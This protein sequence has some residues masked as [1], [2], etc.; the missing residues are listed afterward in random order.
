MLDKPPSEPKWQSWAYVAGFSCVIFLTVPFARALQSL[1]SDSVGR[2][3]FLI[4]VV[5]AGTFAAFFAWRSIRH[6]EL[7]VSAYIALVAVGTAFAIY[8]YALRENPEEALHFVEY[9]ILGVL[10]YRA[11]T[12]SVH[13]V[14]IY[15]SAALIVT[16]VGVIDEWIQ[17]LTPRR[18]WDLRDI[19]INCVAG[20]LTQV[21]IFAGLRPAVANR[22]STPKSLTILCRTAAATVF[23]FGLTFINTP[24]RT[25]ALANAF[26]SLS[27][28]TENRNIMV[29][30]GYLYDESDIGIFRSRFTTAELVKLDRE[31]GLELAPIVDEYV[32]EERFRE[33]LGIYTV[34]RD[35]Y[36][37]EVGVHLFRR[38]RYYSRAQTEPDEAAD[39]YNVA[40]REQQFLD[41]YFSTTMSNSMH[42][43][44]PE[45]RAEVMAGAD[46]TERYES[47]VSEGLIT[48]LTERQMIGGLSAATVG[49]LVLSG[50]FS[51]RH[52]AD[53]GESRA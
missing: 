24:D 51:R 48:K 47:R 26:P 12:H 21:A 53:N 39:H 44:A 11:L 22:K 32:N 10:A 28:L 23:L 17:W 27:F 49:L 33:F 4:A 3:A 31:R 34:I 36:A 7:P 16:A 42:V 8:T 38:N 35:A 14:T 40:L 46:T 2:G 18:V 52:R 13:D 45:V 30:Y 19:R 25:V 1:V 41:R 9:G 15:V 6:R 50:Y 43:W 5:L 20:V 29:Q 37:H